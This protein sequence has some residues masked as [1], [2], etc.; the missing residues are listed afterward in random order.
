MRNELPGISVIVCTWNRAETLRVS[1]QSLMQQRGYPSECVEVIVVDNNSTDATKAVVEGLATGWTLGALHYA[2]EP[3][4][5]KQFALNQGIALAKF[6]ILAFT[7]DDIDFPENWLL[8]I[9]DCFSDPAV[10]LAG[11]KTLIQW[12]PAG[13][14]TW[15]ADDMLAILAGVDLG[16]A[17]LDPSPSDYAPG[18]SNLI[19]RRELF[20]RVGGYS[21]AH[22]RHMDHEFGLRCQSRGVRIV[23]D[24][25]LVV[26][27][28]VDERC[29]TLRYFRR[30][31]FKAGLARSGGASAA[32]N[33]PKVPAWLYRQAIEDVV[34]VF[35]A[36]VLPL[37]P[38]R[39]SRDLRLWRAWGTIANAWHGWLRPQG[40]AAWVMRKSQKKQGLY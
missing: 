5:G 27:A 11:G 40:H 38:E 17:R 26:R 22:F 39:F 15:Y 4:Q 29:L 31:S 9:A 2:F 1:L 30:W 13:R 25:A 28:P 20:D 6:P 12:G 18:G 33:K 35:L 21:E 34:A 10:Q 23:Y 24:P 19:A 16:D 7:D 14:P 37:T 36:K 32:G 8:R 3:R